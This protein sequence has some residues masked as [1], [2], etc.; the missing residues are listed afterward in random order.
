V[1]TSM[2]MVASRP[3]VSFWPDGCSSP[4]DYECLFV[5]LGSKWR[6]VVSFT[7]LPL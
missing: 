2:T 3:E 1:T 5:D 4:G 6:W 7:S